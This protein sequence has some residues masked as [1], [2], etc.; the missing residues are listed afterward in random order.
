MLWVKS[1]H[2]Q[3]TKCTLSYPMVE[4]IYYSDGCNTNGTMFHWYYVNELHTTHVVVCQV[5]TRCASPKWEAG[6]LAEISSSGRII[7]LC[8]ISSKD[9]R[10]SR[11]AS[12]RWGLDYWL[13]F[14]RSGQIIWPSSKLAK[15]PGA[16]LAGTG[17]DFWPDYLVRPEVLARPDYPGQTWAGISGL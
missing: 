2:V 17:V 13:D 14:S 9:L 5:T 10:S 16:R 12:P 8:S 15:D 4:G 6:L 11:C 7:R 3:T 1:N